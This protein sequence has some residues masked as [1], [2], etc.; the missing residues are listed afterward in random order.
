MKVQNLFSVAKVET[1]DTLKE[2]SRERGTLYFRL[3]IVPSGNEETLTDA[4]KAMLAKLG[5]MARN[6]TLKGQLTREISNVF[7]ATILSDYIDGLDSITPEDLTDETQDELISQLSD[8]L[9]GNDEKGNRLQFIFTYYTFSVADLLKGTDYEGAEKLYT[10]NGS[11]VRQRNN[12]YFGFFDDEEE[13]FSFMRSRLI[14]AIEEEDL[15]TEAPESEVKT[16]SDTVTDAWL[17]A[18][19]GVV[20]RVPVMDENGVVI[21]PN[22]CNGC[23]VCAKVC[24]FHAIEI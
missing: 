3:A 23:G 1:N 17:D 14:S 10:E 18:L 2:T 13:A 20:K 9:K 6:I 8:I 22:Q 15:T 16:E 5:E 19:G 11:I 24:P 4:Q 7:P 12:L 21:D